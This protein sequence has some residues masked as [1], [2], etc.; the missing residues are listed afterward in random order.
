MDRFTLEV[1][2]TVANLGSG[3]DAI[4]VAIGL[5][6]RVIVELTGDGIAVINEG[7]YADGLAGAP[8]D[9]RN[10]LAKTIL[11]VAGS[12]AP[13]NLRITQHLGAPVGRGFGSSASAIVAGLFAARALGLLDED[14]ELAPLAI[15]IEGHPDNVMPCL[16]GG[17]TATGGETTIR[18]EP[19]ADW[20][21][22]LAI[23]PAMSRTAETRT[24]LP[25]T[26]SRGDAAAQAARAALLGIALGCGDLD[27]LFEG[28][29]DVIHQPTRLAAMPESAVIVGAWRARGIPAFLSGAGPSVCAIVASADADLLVAQLGSDVPAGWELRAARLRSEGARIVER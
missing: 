19:H 6:T 15:A 14:T 7:P 28:T 11:D 27:A 22:L 12:D 2:A 16:F 20:R 26:F 3:F 21:M 25:D 17:I 5:T 23:A 24:A 1:P 10:L 13:R 18:I 8:T 9:A 4:G 29:G